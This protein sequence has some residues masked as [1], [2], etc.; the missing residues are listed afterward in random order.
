LDALDETL[1]LEP[2]CH[3]AWYD[4]SDILRFLNRAEDA[5]EAINRV[6]RCV[7]E[8]ASAWHL[9]GLILGEFLDDKGASLCPFDISQNDQAVDAFDEAILLEP[10]YFAARL[11]KAQALVRSCHAAQATYRVIAHVAGEQLGAE[12]AED[13]LRPFVRSFECCFARACESFDA[14]IRVGPDDYRPWYGKARL[15][16]ELEEGHEMGAIEAFSRAVELQPDLAEGWYG[17]AKIHAKQGEQEESQACLRQA[18]H[19]D[20]SLEDRAREDF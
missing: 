6:L 15:L 17:L 16:V 3:P 2:G 19:V 12:M 20:P 1:K 8:R 9:K 7:P 13:Y 5:L 18:I 14:A 4:K 10:D 11:S